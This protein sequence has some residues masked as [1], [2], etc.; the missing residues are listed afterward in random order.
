MTNTA[1]STFCGWCS[2][3]NPLIVGSCQNCGHDA[4]LSAMD[5]TCSVCRKGRPERAVFPTDIGTL[6]SSAHL[7]ADMDKMI[8]RWSR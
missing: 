4:H 2:Q 7:V 6:F 1:T 3:E 8:K 5:C